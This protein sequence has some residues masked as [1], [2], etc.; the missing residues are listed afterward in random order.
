[1]KL[2]ACLLALLA[3]LPPAWAA[4]TTPESPQEAVPAAV[5]ETVPEP[6][7]AEAPPA[8]DIVPEAPPAEP[9]AMPP[10]R[11]V[12]GTKLLFLRLNLR[13]KQV[14]QELLAISADELLVHLAVAGDLL[15]Q[16]R[17]RYLTD[18]ELAKADRSE[19]YLQSL[20][21]RYVLLA[22]PA[23]ESPAAAEPGPAR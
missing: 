12:I 6:A 20:T 18:D 13:I 4:E 21:E 1:M 14:E 22:R 10:S 7:M 23:A 19:Q 17:S 5:P 16:L 15:R 8:M 9:P 2:R 11:P 3:F